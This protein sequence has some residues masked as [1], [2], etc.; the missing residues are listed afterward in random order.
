MI[1]STKVKA[2]T[3]T[4]DKEKTRP[5]Q[6]HIWPLPTIPLM[7]QSHLN[8]PSFLNILFLCSLSD[9][10]SFAPA[11]SRTPWKSFFTKEILSSSHLPVIF[12][13]TELCLSLLG[14]HTPIPPHVNSTLFICL[15]VCLLNKFWTAGDMSMSH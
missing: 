1:C 15:C 11:V 2:G 6:F 7:L 4:H 13:S 10:Q 5:V 3:A 12:T 8:Y 14:S 9:S